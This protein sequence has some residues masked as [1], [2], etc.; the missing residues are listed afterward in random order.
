M[1]KRLFVSITL[2][3]EWWDAFVEYYSQFPAQDA[4]WTPKEN[5]HITACFLGDVD[6]THIDEIKEKLKNLCA[7][8]ESFSLSFENISFAPPGMPPRMIWAMF[9]PS[10][11]YLKLTEEMQ[12][13]L[14]SFLSAEPHKEVVP[15][16]TLA[17]FKNPGLAKEID[18]SRSLPKLASFDVHSVE[19]VE[20]L[21]D[22]V[23]VRYETLET[24][25]LAKNA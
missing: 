8:I 4:R 1:K 10:D 17:R 13:T 2:P 18:L 14:R 3:A 21:L 25:S 19:L 22:P 20:S 16:A 5:I 15:H 11:A 9:A 7:R 6:A 23:G 24:F 12:E